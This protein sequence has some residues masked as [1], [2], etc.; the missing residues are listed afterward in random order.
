MTRI[1]ENFLQS[2]I[3]LYPSEDDALKNNEKGGTGFL[4]GMANDDD[5]ITY[6]VLLSLVN[7]F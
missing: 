5:H 3:Y 2:I 6:K 7:I 4:L 1:N